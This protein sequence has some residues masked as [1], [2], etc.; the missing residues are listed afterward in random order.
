M[1]KHGP[2]LLKELRKVSPLLDALID[3]AL[4]ENIRILTTEDY[5]KLISRFWPVPNDNKM[6]PL[7]AGHFPDVDL[8]RVI[9]IRWPYIMEITGSDIGRFEIGFAHE[10]GHNL[11][12]QDRPFCGKD[13]SSSKPPI[14]WACANFEILAYSCALKIIGRLRQ[15]L[16]FSWH[17]FFWGKNTTCL[18][19]LQT[20]GYPNKF[21]R[22]MKD[23][24]GLSAYQLKICPKE[25]ET[26]KMAREI[27]ACKF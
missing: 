2:D 11:T 24:K 5:I 25:K 17:P 22:N 9:V 7:A 16:P 4:S 23:C 13:P 6:L 19:T 1:F 26:I 15:K 18:K 12:W 10:I 20:F 8:A 21:I 3:E 14:F 27:E